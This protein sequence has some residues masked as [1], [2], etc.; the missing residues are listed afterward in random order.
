MSNFP[1]SRL[2]SRRVLIVIGLAA[3]ALQLA[4]RQNL[5][6]AS[7]GKP[8][9]ALAPGDPGTLSGNG[10][11]EVLLDFGQVALG[12]QALAELLLAD[13][14]SSPLQILAVDAPTDPEFAISLGPGVG[15]QTGRSVHIPCN[16]KP[17]SAGAK[18][19]SVQ[20]HTDSQSVPTITLKLQGMGVIVKLRVEPQTV[21]FGTVVTH[22]ALT[23]S[24]TV[25]NQSALDLTVK[26]SAIEGNGATLFA[27]DPVTAATSFTLPAGAS[28][29]IS[30]TYQP[31]VPSVL[32]MLDVAHIILAPSIGPPVIVTLQGVALESGLLLTPNPM[33]FNFV[34]PGQISAKTLRIKNIG[35][36]AINVTQVSVTNPGGGVFAIPSGMITSATALSAGN[37]LDIPVQFSPTGDALY[38]G[39]ISV[40][41]NDNLGHAAVSLQGFGGGAAISCAPLALDFGV[42]AAGIGST[43]FVLCTN[44]GTDVTN[45]P[46]AGLLIGNLPTSTA[47]FDVTPA[48]GTP[49]G[50]LRAGQTVVLDVA[51]VPS[52]ATIDSATLTVQSNAP[53]PPTPPVIN[54]SGQGIVVGKCNYDIAPISLNW[55]EVPGTDKNLR[56]T[57][58]YT[59]EN[60][61][62]NTCVVDGLRLSQSNG[63]AFAL[64]DGP[65]VSQLLAAPGQPQLVDGGALPIAISVAVSFAAAQGAGTYAGQVAFTISDPTAANQLVNLTALAADSCFLLQPNPLDLGTVGLASNGQFCQKNHRQFLGIN[66][67]AQDV[68][69]TGITTAGAPFDQVASPS[70]PVTLPGGSSST[71]FVIGFSP[72]GAGEFYGAVKLQTDLQTVPFALTVHGKAIA[73]TQQTDT[74]QGSST[75]AVDV[76]WVVDNDDFEREL[77][78]FGVP[79]DLLDKLSDF[80]GA[81][82]PGV[83]YQMGVTSDECPGADNG[84]LEPCP[85]CTIQ[86]TT[87]TIV[88]PSTSNPGGKLEDLIKRVGTLGGGGACQGNYNATMLASWTALQPGI[89]AGHNTGFL[90]DGATLAVIV[91]DPDGYAE[92]DG[93]PQTTDFYLDFFNSLKGGNQLVNVSMMYTGLYGPYPPTPR[94]TSLTLKS[95]GQLIDTTGPDWTKQINQLWSSVSA[96]GG[97]ILTGTPIPDTIQVWLD[98]PPPRPGVTAH[99]LQLQQ[100][101]PNGTWNWQYLTGS[102][103]IVVNTQ[104]IKLGANDTLAAVYTLTC[105]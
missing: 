27:Y 89:L 20:I 75:A 52:Q 46:E 57:Q 60:L 64:P 58:A 54:L 13:V 3:M 5:V 92:D 102:N 48:P 41:S 93:S 8:S 103:S 22:S 101:N 99:G 67:C 85:T 100:Q 84:N 73:G 50:Y 49:Q 72:T 35:N 79:P 86:G 105:E 28:Q 43:Q 34:Q 90:R 6:L 95:G 36:Q 19:T 68:T 53:N 59:I 55:G 65:I 63:G 24:I 56:Y 98:G 4:C 21:D 39:E 83:D 12:Q 32:S 31:V 80:V 96:G 14:G 47:A 1:E 94:Y 44:T 62:P 16:F 11:S 9:L 33:D 30:F 40:V 2:P 25:T 7:S 42:V 37:E 71:P 70:L 15:I 78:Y 97:F 74:F 82:Q 18:S 77:N 88:T 38:S 87:P 23:K 69:L 45:H 51:Y 66:N 91:Y 26:E 61:G 76:L 29:S 81:V 10:N 17:F 104:N